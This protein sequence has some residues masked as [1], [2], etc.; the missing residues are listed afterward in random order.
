VKLVSLHEYEIAILN[1][2]KKERSAAFDGLQGSL[3]IARDSL[4][5]AIE[6]LS[7]EGLVKIDKES[8]K[9]SKA[10]AEGAKYLK[11]FPE[12]ELVL[13]MDKAGGNMPMSSIKNEIGIVWAKRNGWITME[14]GHV[15][16]T[17]K[18]KA[19][20]KQDSKY[21]QKELLNRLSNAGQ[22]GADRTINDSKDMVEVL[23]NRNLI[24]IVDRS[25]IKS[26][27]ITEKGAGSVQKDGTG[28][29][30]L[31]RDIITSRKWEKEK[32]RPYDIQASTEEMY[33]AR[34][35]PLHEFL[36]VIRQIW[37]N[38]GFTEVS[39]PIIEPAFWVFDALFSPQDHPTRDMQDT[40][41]LKNPSKLSVDD[42]A[43]M[44]RVKK[45]HQTGWK[46]KWREEIAQQAILRTHTTSVSAHFINK[47]ANAEEHSYPLKFFTVGRNFR[48]E[49]VD[50]K[51]LAEFYMFEGIIIGNN[52][53]LS[54]LIY[55]LKQ[56]YSQLGME[57]L[58]FR[59][60]YFPFVEP[61]LEICYYD[62]KKKDTIE[63]GGAG[64]I[65]KEITK[66]MG[67][68]K[69]VLAWGPGLDRLMFKAFDIDTLTKLYNNDVGW[70]RE[71]KELRI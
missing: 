7:K 32:M 49:S 54:N 28:I 47:Y 59:P 64:I 69:T 9:V 21:E 51:H 67:T 16:L 46:E 70:L 41:F 43:L 36:D 30:A 37:L 2:L 11:H 61:G 31:S 34:L 18:G 38:M 66:A 58:V 57:N 13:S 53:T 48:N 25:T 15:T 10:T 50:Y 62:E 33:P 44:K 35:H 65:R 8:S 14:K 20:A 3:G 39:G 63:L 6:N 26:I 19:A 5:W 4:L 60:A 56:F 29:G 52:L 22:G 55:T 12:E 71:R 24:E 40:F 68:N 27:T 45:M 17:D 42:I 23:K 1:L